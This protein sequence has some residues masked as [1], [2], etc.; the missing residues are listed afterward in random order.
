M[1]ADCKSVSRLLIN[2]G[3]SPPNYVSRLYITGKMEPCVALM[4]SAEP[5]GRLHI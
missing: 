3:T 5:T 2:R 1:T 4:G